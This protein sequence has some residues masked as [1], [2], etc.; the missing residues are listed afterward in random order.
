MLIFSSPFELRENGAL[1]QNKYI[2]LFCA[3]IT[4]KN[5]AIGKITH[6]FCSITRDWI[7]S[8]TSLPMDKFCRC[9]YAY[10]LAMILAHTTQYSTG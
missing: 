3:M 6:K 9:A 8:G 10:S 4:M 5:N 1:L 2:Y 7:G